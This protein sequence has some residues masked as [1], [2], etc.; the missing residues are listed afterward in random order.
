[1]KKNK[2]INIHTGEKTHTCTK[3]NIHIENIQSYTKI[4][5]SHAHTHTHTHTH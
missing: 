1:M 4:T 5:S 2:L 3:T